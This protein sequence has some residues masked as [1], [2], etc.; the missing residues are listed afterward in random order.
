ML[1]YSTAVVHKPSKP[2]HPS[3]PMIPSLDPKITDLYITATTPTSLTLAATMNITNPTKYSAVVPYID[4][5]LLVNGTTLGHATAYNVSVVPG[6]NT[7]VDIVAIW[8]PAAAEGEHSRAVGRELLSQYISGYNTSLTLQPH[9]LSIPA[10]P[11]ISR[12]LST[13]TFE[14]PTPRLGPPAPPPP[15]RDPDFPDDGEDEDDDSPKFITDATMHLFTSTAQ[16]TLHSPLQHSSLLITHLNATAHYRPEPDAESNEVG[17]ILY[18]PF[19]P[20]IV[21]PGE[22]R[23]PRLPVTWDLGGVGYKAV[24][25]ALGGTL[26][27]EARAIVGVGI[28]RWRERV[29]FVGRGVGVGVR[30]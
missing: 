14:L 17:S 21:A 20:M 30:L 5:L 15:P 19:P 25:R 3:A 4:I 1:I 10:L 24:R 18:E 26:K 9:H 7:N 23:S 28:G 6:L 8:E 16:F 22:S 2:G 11:L 13:F 12:T 29:W 27:L